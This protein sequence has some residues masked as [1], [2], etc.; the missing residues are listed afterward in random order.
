MATKEVEFHDPKDI[1]DSEVMSGRKRDSAYK[2][3]DE[4]P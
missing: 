2:I 3:N 4:D 1:V